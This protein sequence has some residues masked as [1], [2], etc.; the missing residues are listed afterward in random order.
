[1]IDNSGSMSWL[2]GTRGG[3]DEDMVRFSI[4]RDLMDS[5]HRVAPNTQ[6][7]LV[8]FARRLSFDH[9]DNAYFERAFPNDPVF[10]DSYVPLT[11]LNAKFP[12]GVPGLDT[13]KA[14]L[15]YTGPGNLAYATTR[16]D[17]RTGTDITIAFQAA[18]RALAASKA[19]KEDQYVIF[20]SDGIPDQVDSTRRA[21]ERDYVAGTGVPTTFG[22]YFMEKGAKVVEPKP[23]IA[24]MIA[25][26]RVNGYSSNNPT[27]DLWAVNLRATTLMPLLQ[28]KV[29]NPIFADLPAVPVGVNIKTDSVPVSSIASDSGG[30]T[31]PA[32]IPLSPGQTKVQ[33]DFSYTYQDST[34]PKTKVVPYTVSIKRIPSGN[35]FPVGVDT[36]CLE[37]GD[38]TLYSQGKQ[39]SEL[40]PSTHSL[41]ARLRLP[42][43]QDC[44]A[45]K[46][47]LET[48]KGQPVDRE[49]LGLLPANGKFSASFSTET[50]TETKPAALAGN[51]TIQFARSDSLILVYVNPLNP[52]DTIRAAFRYSEPDLPLAVLAE[53]FDEDADGIAD[54]IKIKYDRDIALLPPARAAW[55]WPSGALLNPVPL[56][57]L[58]AGILPG[59]EVDLKIA[60]G[61]TVA[62]AGTGAYVSTYA[63]L[64][65]DSTQSIAIQD[66][67]APVLLS[68]EMANGPVGDTLRLRFSEPVDEKAILFGAIELFRFRIFEGGADQ[69]FSPQAIAWKDGNRRLD[70]IYARG[71]VPKPQPGNLVRMMDGPGRLQDAAGNKPGGNSRFRLITGEKRSEI[72][73]VSYRKIDP[74]F[75]PGP[76]AVKISREP[77]GATVVEIANRTGTLGHLVK[78]D[79][80]DYATGDDFTRIDPGMVVIR[81]Q[82]RYFTN[83]GAFVASA[84]GDVSCLDALYSGDCRKHRGYLF[85]GWNFLSDDGQKAGT[86]A[87]VARIRYTISVAGKP[88]GSGALDQT[89]GL[90]R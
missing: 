6:V 74:G 65:K 84:Q 20:L 68:A 48:R 10:H 29:L 7:A 1:V 88:V 28:E 72:L 78:V 75:V 12:N 53:A 22:V 77:I 19:A 58:T 25:N 46:L 49:S 24:T 21:I 44:P 70:L 67:I 63:Y 3:S 50:T 31:F 36:S 17:T 38:I 61:K 40:D 89:W 83:L 52:L 64:G 43:G 57:K 27:S 30:F 85:I 9:R 73:T 54:R 80:G 14:L 82:T 59:G 18:K 32:R 35:P 69:L 42:N 5:I 81:Y 62:T 34:G 76:R 37:A 47:R 51:G 39:V 66:R 87:Y 15:K 8:A 55:Q 45:C 33:L 56:A 2:D 11:A 4:V 86:G 16:T 26:I 41:E 79:L 13:L 23:D 90:L 71:S 60:P